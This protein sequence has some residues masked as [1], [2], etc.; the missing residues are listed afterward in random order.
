MAQHHKAVV[1]SVLS[2]DTVILRG[3]PRPNGPPAERLLA[4]SNVQAPRLGNASRDDEQFAFGA[5][6]YLRKLL[7]GKEVTFVPEYTIS[8]INPP[9]EY[10]SIL[11]ANGDNVAH[12]GVQ[13]GWLKVREGKSKS[14]QDDEAHEQE[15][16]E[17]RLLEEEAQLTKRGQWNTDIDGSRQVSYTMEKDARSFLNTYKGKPLDAIIEQVR[18][19]STYRVLLILPDQSQQIITLF[20]SG[21]KAPSCKRDNLPSDQT[22]TTPSEPFGEEAKYFVEVRLLQR[23]V[24]VILEGI[25]QGGSQN[26]V[27]SIQHPAGN[28]SE[29]LLANG[30][31]K[32]VDWSIT[33]TTGGPLALRKAEKVA[34]DKKLRIWKDFVAKEKINDSEFDAQVIKIVTG[35]TIVVKTKNGTERKLQLASIKQAPRGTGSTAPGGSAKSRDVKEVGYQFEAR[36]FLRKKLI[37]KQ[38]HVVIDYKKPAQD[39]FEAKDCATV[40]LGNNNIAQQLLEKGLA[41]AIRHR[42]DDDNR[43]HHYDQ[44]LIAETKA[45]EQQKGVHSTKGQ[46][47]VRIV[48]ASENMTKARQFLT[49][50][51]RNQRQVAVVDHVA[52]GSRLFLWIPKENCRLSFVLAGIRAPRVGKN[53][54]EK[55]EPFGPEA[56]AFVTEQCLQHDVEVE[57]DNVDKTGAF[58][59]NLFIGGNNLAIELLNKGYATVHEY[60]ANESRYANQFFGAERN[61]KESRQGL[62]ENAQFEDEQQEQQATISKA[63]EAVLQPRH[64]YIDIVI[65]DMV[66]G[67]HFFV[68]V[69]NPIEIKQL[70]VLMKDL[71]V[72]YKNRSEPASRPRVGDVVSAKFTEDD[73]WYRAKVRRVSAEGIEVLYI[74]YGNSETLPLSRIQPLASQ[75]KSLKPQAQEAVLSFVKSPAKDADYGVECMERFHELTAGKQLVANVDARENGVLC[76]T[77]YDPV[78]STSAEASINLEMVRD[79]Q[80]IVTPKVRYAAA[81]PDIIKSLQEAENAARRERIGMFEYGDITAT[82]DDF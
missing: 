11:L 71:T 31:A 15:L 40:T 38:V 35:D 34:K 73:C 77:V 30:M 12:L 1:K 51:K 80:A 20:L 29:L 13:Q 69:I 54:S 68:Q 43:S 16:N 23:G 3:K 63:Q 33:M 32:C 46:P 82:E 72:Y 76:L 66:S 59:G 67:S 8:T 47:I 56:L 52:N 5:R 75:F 22:D 44:L 42:K 14:N 64:E 28:I 27:G 37:G 39:G 25:S 79:G 4:L 24:K 65:S 21:I 50:L 74:D 53:A 19:A 2:G 17:L 62:W 26:F 57:I 55:S 10:G 41:T 45:Q 36:E 7:V 6:E 61:A 60:S 58:I 81:Y 49:S 18:D 78:Q 70:E 9:R 48:D